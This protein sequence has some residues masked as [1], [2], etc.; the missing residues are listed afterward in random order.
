MPNLQNSVSFDQRLLMKGIDIRRKRATFLVK[1]PGF[2]NRQ[3]KISETGTVLSWKT[4]TYLTTARCHGE[5]WKKKHSCL[6]LTFN[7]HRQ[8]YKT[9]RHQIPCTEKF[10]Y[11]SWVWTREIHSWSYSLI[12]FIQV[13]FCRI[14]SFS[15]NQMPIMSTC[16]QC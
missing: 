5:F 7:N 13:E 14:I 16:T 1:E 15:C 4:A 12:T 10:C 6:V 11:M 3:M 8:K 9:W 2:S